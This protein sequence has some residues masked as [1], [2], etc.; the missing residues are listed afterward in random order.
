M[1]AIT[2]VPLG[3]VY[4]KKSHAKSVALL[5]HELVHVR[6]QVWDGKWR[7]FLRYIFSGKWRLK[8]EAEAYT[9]NIRNGSLTE[10]EAAN[11]LSSSMYLWCASRNEAVVALRCVP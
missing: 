7:F 4:V 5:Q 9:T 3:A 1:D 8:Y 2:L 10:S 6:Q 11:L